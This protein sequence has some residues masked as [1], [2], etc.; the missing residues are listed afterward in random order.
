MIEINKNYQDIPEGLCNDLHKKAL[1]MALSEK[2]NH[3]FSNLYKKESIKHLKSIYFEKC[4]YCE[5]N[6]SSGYYP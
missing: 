1:L 6:G 4:A 2:E 5:S 3:K